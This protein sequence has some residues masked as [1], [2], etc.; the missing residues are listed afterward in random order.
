M[1]IIKLLGAGN[2]MSCGIYK[3]TNKL[4]NK[5]Y[6]R[7]S[8]NI[9]MRWIAHIQYIQKIDGEDNYFYQQVRKY[10]II[11][12]TFEI[13][14]ECSIDQLNEREKYWFKQ[15]NCLK[16]NGYNSQVPIN[17]NREKN[18]TIKKSFTPKKIVNGFE[19]T[20]VELVFKK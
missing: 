11:N 14:E 7:Q 1:D 4:N 6:I 17:Y 5:C 2:N 20:P 8:A 19:Y 15:Y 3:I 12:F 16:P 9:E 13:I 18:S 10:G